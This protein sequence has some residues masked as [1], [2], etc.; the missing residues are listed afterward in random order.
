MQIAEDLVK[1]G[2]SSGEV[3]AN[4]L[5]EFV[6]EHRFTKLIETGTY[7]GIGT[8]LSIIRGLKLPYEFISIEV[9]PEHYRIAQENLKDIPGVYLINGLSIGRPE[10]PVSI[11]ADFPE[12]V[13]VDHHPV[14][15]ERLYRKEVKHHV[16]DNQLERALAHFD[17][18]P[19]FVLLDSA[20]HMGLIEFK[21][22]MKRLKGSCYIALD[23]TDHVK[24][25]DTMQVVQSDPRFEIIWQVRSV[26]FQGGDKFG[27]AIIRYTHGM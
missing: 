16:D 6:A 15:R 20:G 10:L 1:A 17:Y 9:N 22:L 19:E 25:Y 5:T 3:F 23:D 26:Q 12:F 4:K 27:S 18:Q 8:T 11:S 21:Y 7:H 13:V 14:N 2:M 24:H